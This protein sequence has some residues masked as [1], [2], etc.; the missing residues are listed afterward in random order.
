[1]QIVTL[2]TGLFDDADTVIKAA[3]A[4]VVDLRTELNEKE[5]DDVLEQIMDADLVV[6]A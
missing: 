3:A 1:M 5:W 4:P 2:Q 6:T